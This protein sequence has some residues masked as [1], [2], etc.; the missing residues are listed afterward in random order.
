VTRLAPAG[1]WPGVRPTRRGFLQLVLGGVLY[2][3][4]ANVGSTWVVLLAAAAM[5]TVGWGLVS[6]AR[7]VRRVHVRRDVPAVVEAGG[8]VAAGISATTPTTALLVVRDALTGLGGAAPAGTRLAGTFLPARGSQVGGEVRVLV[9]DRF[10]LA[11]GWAAGDVATPLLAL[12]AVPPRPAPPPGRQ[13]A[14]VEPVAARAGAGTEVLGVRAYRSGDPPRAVH[15]RATARHGRLVVRETAWEAG[16]TLVVALAGGTWEAAALDQA[17]E[18]ACG[19]AAAAAASGR[20][21]ELAVDGRRLPWSPAARR[22]LALL[23]PHAG[24]PPR[25]LAPP[26]QSSSSD[27]ILLTPEPPR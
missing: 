18:E 26:P 19:L 10:G 15:W 1:P 8:P 5:G 22:D 4:G 25:P 24:A 14:G 16:P 21:V 9:A 12:P 23:P 11:R 7:A 27:T 13:A 6:A 3:A 17:A 2:L 20:P